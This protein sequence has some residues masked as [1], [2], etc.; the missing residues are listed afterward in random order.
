MPLFC[1][2]EL[3]GAIDPPTKLADVFQHGGIP[4]QQAANTML[5]K[6]GGYIRR[7]MSFSGINFNDIVLGDAPTAENPYPE[8]YRKSDAFTSPMRDILDYA[9][10]M[11]QLVD[12]L[13]TELMAEGVVIDG[14]TVADQLES[15]N[16][17][18]QVHNIVNQY[19]FAIKA[20]DVARRAV[21]ELKA[22]RKPVITVENTMEGPLTEVVGMG[23]APNFKGLLARYLENTHMVTRGLPAPTKRFVFAS[24][25]R[26]MSAAIIQRFE[27]SRQN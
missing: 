26:S 16:F 9:D 23:E 22:G 11:F 18:A 25:L 8:Q 5:A 24:I 12:E 10:E 20:K 21:D 19:L 13:N 27:S 4:L 7:E 1:K 14:E 2:T 17:N 6:A 15:T 3:G